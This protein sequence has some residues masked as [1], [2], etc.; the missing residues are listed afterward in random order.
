MT[1]LQREHRFEHASH[2][3]CPKKERNSCYMGYTFKTAPG[4]RYSLKII[5][6]HMSIL[7]GN[8]EIKTERMVIAVLNRLHLL[9]SVECLK[10][11]GFQELFARKEIKN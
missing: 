3:N 1:Y 8:E 9:R 11:N 6:S 7:A 10:G 4:V 2:V 5:F